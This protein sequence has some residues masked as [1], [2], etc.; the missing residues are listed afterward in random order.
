MSATLNKAT[1]FTVLIALIAILANGTVTFAQRDSG[2]KARGEIGKGFWSSNSSRAPFSGG[3]STETRRSFSHAPSGQGEMSAPA[4]K[5]ADRRGC[6]PSVKSKVTDEGE[7]QAPKATRRAFSY[8]PKMKARS[9]SRSSG[10]SKK[11]PWS[12]QKT[13][14]RRYQH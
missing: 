9:G 11:E 14:P 4:I 13:D 8:E 10:K 6:N 12:Y 7:A 2:A 3:W 1:V 5:N